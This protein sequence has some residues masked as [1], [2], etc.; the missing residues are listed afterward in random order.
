VAEVADLST[1][2]ARIYIPEFAMRDIRTGA[3]VRLQPES[4]IVP[5]TS[6]LFSVTPASTVIEP[7]LVPKDQLKGITPPRF[8]VGSALLINQGDLREGMTGTAKIL[9]TR[10]S[11]VGFTWR[12]GRDLVDRRIW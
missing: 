4:R 8:Y 12:F 11:I 6:V 1:M 9:V 5:I 2:K 7:G 10:R 3:R